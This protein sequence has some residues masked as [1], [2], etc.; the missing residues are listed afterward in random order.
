TPDVVSLVDGESGELVGTMELARALSTVHEGAVYLHLGRSFEVR[1]LDLDHRRALL[2]PFSGDWFTQPKRETETGIERLLDRRETLGVRLSYGEV[3]VTEQVLG[4]Q[5]KRIADHAVIDFH[6]VDVP[7]SS[8]R[9]R[10][11][12]FELDDLLAAHRF[13]RELLLGALHAMEHGQIAVLPLLAMCD[14]W[15]IGGLSTNAHPLTL[16]PTFFIY[17]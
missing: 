3:V 1:A 16:T 17:D 9:T 10:A 2:T 4:Y 8:F 7:P 6:V 12:W 11:L 15:D 14:R 5:R 13:P